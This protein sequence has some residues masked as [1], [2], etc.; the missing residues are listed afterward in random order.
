MKVKFE[1]GEKIVAAFPKHLVFKYGE[2]AE[3]LEGRSLVAKPTYRLIQ[4]VQ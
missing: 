1:S 3:L 4:Y 2:K